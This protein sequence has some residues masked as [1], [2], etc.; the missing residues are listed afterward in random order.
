MVTLLRVY[1]VKRL[2]A[3]NSSSFTDLGMTSLTERLVNKRTGQ[4]IEY[5]EELVHNMLAADQNA[6][7]LVG[8]IVK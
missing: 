3:L 1:F 6:G 4:D 2:I 7:V 8:F 5:Q